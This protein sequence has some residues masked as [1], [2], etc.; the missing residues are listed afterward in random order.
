MDVDATP[1]GTPAHKKT[2]VW[3]AL[4]MMHEILPCAKEVEYMDSL[5]KV[6]HFFHGRSI[7]TWSLFAG[8]GLSAKLLPV[9]EAFL[10]DRY[11][12]QLTTQIA[13]MCE[14]DE[15]KLNFLRQQHGSALV[16]SDNVA[17]LERSAVVNR[18]DAACP[19]RCVLPQCDYSDIGVPCQARSQA[20]SKSSG[21][22]NCV[23][24]QRETT[25]LGFLAASRA[26][27]VNEPW[28]GQMECVTP[29]AV[30]DEKKSPISDARHM[31]VDLGKKGYW[32]HFSEVESEEY[33]HCQD[34][35]RLW[36]PYAKMIKSRWPAATAWYQDLLQSFKLHPF[37]F[38]VEDFLVHNEADR[39]II[40]KDIGLPLWSSFGR[41]TSTVCKEA[42]A[43]WSL[44]HYRIARAN[45]IDWP[46][47]VEEM[48][49]PSSIAFFG[50]R[51]RECE[52]V[53][54]ADKLWPP[55]R[56]PGSPDIE[57]FDCNPQTLRVLKGHIDEETMKLIP[58]EERQQTSGYGPW[59]RVLV[60]Q[61]GSGKIIVRYK[62]ATGHIIRL[63]EAFESM[64]LIGWDTESW[65]QAPECKSE[66]DLDA[67]VNLVGNAFYFAHFLPVFLSV[68]STFGRYSTDNAEDAGCDS[69]GDND[70]KGES[71]S[72]ASSAAS[73]FH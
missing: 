8:T 57:S 45:D 58:V 24:E 51:Q 50:L 46:F 40:A 32:A 6:A 10:E 16:L 23:Q 35:K 19:V 38:Q 62:T 9:V 11:G 34:R 7:H 20:S 72:V 22:V 2:I 60:T 59:K 14:K 53:C 25:G 30:V 67:I 39:Q 54:F 13:V 17:D 70:D 42:G 1:V 63:I 66:K 4:N 33:G 55:R 31:V 44:E 64:R 3:R 15:D 27:A 28:F 65:S 21:N 43:D 47:V 68:L 18:K 12:I 37:T 69:S 61:I 26:V 5:R 56:G 52:L 29:L 41:R 36:W 49:T 48:V 73:L 71:V